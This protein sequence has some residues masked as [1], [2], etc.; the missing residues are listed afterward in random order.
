MGKS[1]LTSIEKR[2]KKIKDRVIRPILSG[3]DIIGVLPAYI[4]ALSL[5]SGIAA[6]ILLQ[7]SVNYFVIVIV[8]CI[9]FD[10]LDGSLARYQKSASEK[11]WWTDYLTDLIV[12]LSVIG[13]SAFLMPGKEIYVIVLLFMHVIVNGVYMLTGRKHQI[14]F[15]KIIYFIIIYFSIWAATIFSIAASTLNIIILLRGIVSSPP[16]KK[17]SR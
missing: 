6:A 16:G 8:A 3:L 15:H 5:I 13:S 17:S 10:G 2:G 7:Y 12:T 1:F 4:T 14:W 11:G 9:I